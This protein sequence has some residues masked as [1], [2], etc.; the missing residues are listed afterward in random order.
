MSVRFLKIVTVLIGASFLLTACDP[1]MPPEVKAALA[2]QS[3]TC[4]L[5]D[6]QLSAPES[7]AAVAGDWQATVEANCPGMTITPASLPSESVE[8]QI[9][10]IIGTPFASVPFAV[11]GVVIA[12][13]LTDITNVNLSAE[14]IEGIW[15]GKI[16]SWNDPLIAALN[17]NFQMPATPIGFGTEL[18]S[19]KSKPLTDWLTRLAGHTI[20]L[21]GGTAK[22]SGLTEGQLVITSY[23]NAMA[24]SLPMVGISAGEGTEGVIPEIGSIN[25]GASMYQSKSV[26]GIVQ[27]TFNPK[28][29]PIAP[30]GVDVAPPPY[31]A[32][33][34]INLNLVGADS[35]K[36][37]AAARYILR[38]DS[39][40]SLGLS[41]VVGLPENLRIIALTE[42]S[43]GLPEPVITEAPT[44]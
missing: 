23:S 1:P 37:R 38:Q 31:Q 44:Q 11:D 12:V 17:P 19:T 33:T 14:A 8:L 35:L 34:I 32:L 15:S 27:L 10:E 4:E 43:K 28:A 13:M 16:I 2:E 5:G 24:L 9:G 25:S 18:E 3:Y 20:T 36:T 29:K 6:T 42:V 41:T 22:L 21:S 7:I 40:G 39:Q 30:E 26:N